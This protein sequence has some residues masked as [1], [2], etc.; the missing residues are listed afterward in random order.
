[1]IVKSSKEEENIHEESTR[2]MIEDVRRCRQNKCWFTSGH[3]GCWQMNIN[4][5]E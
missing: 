2:A 3:S 5:N 4:E 1:M